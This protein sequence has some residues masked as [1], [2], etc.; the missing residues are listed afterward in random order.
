MKTINL[1]GL[2]GDTKGE[3]L[4]GDNITIHFNFS[5]LTTLGNHLKT[6]RRWESETKHKQ[7]ISKHILWQLF[8]PS[9]EWEA[10]W[11]IVVV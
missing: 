11:E 4:M 5:N 9:S 7:N 3:K 1:R 6:S 2:R 10:L 8:V